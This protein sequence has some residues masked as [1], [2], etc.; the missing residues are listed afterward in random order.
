MPIQM[1]NIG[2]GRMLQ[3]MLKNVFLAYILAL[4]TYITKMLTKFFLLQQI[5]Y[6]NGSFIGTAPLFEQLVYWNSSFVGKVPLLEQPL[7]D[8]VPL[9]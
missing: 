9:L 6:W 1:I 5:L 8:T 2:K 7:I 3:Y 4:I